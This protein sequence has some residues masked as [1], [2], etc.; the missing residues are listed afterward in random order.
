MP[1]V[2]IKGRDDNILSKHNN[3]NIKTIYIYIYIHNT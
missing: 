1:K 2:Q 3:S